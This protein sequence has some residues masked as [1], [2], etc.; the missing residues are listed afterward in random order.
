M[1]AQINDSYYYEGEKYS[2]VA[3]EGGKLFNPQEHGFTTFAW[4]TACRRGYVNY[5]EIT[6]EG[7]FLKRLLVAGNVPEEFE[8]VKAVPEGCSLEEYEKMKKIGTAG[9]ED[10]FFGPFIYDGLDLMIDFTGRMVM[11]KDFIKDYYIHM[12]F[13]RAWAYKDLKEFVF[14]KGKLKKVIDHSDIAAKI[15]KRIEEEPDKADELYGEDLCEYVDRSFSMD[16]RDKAWW[17]EKE[18][19]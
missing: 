11:G 6:D 13:Q 17:L 10:G 1:T 14:E 8:G 15:R 9:W 3:I 18:L 2:P 7:L 5:Y 4:C 19:F 12:G 16:I